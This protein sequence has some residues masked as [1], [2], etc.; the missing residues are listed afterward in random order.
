MSGEIGLGSSQMPSSSGGLLGAEQQHSD[1]LEGPKEDDPKTEG[2]IRPTRWC[3]PVIN[4]FI[5]PLT[6]DIS[7]INHSYWVY[8]PT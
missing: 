5:S 4:G 6:I 7:P 1:T 8:K 2:S 3:P